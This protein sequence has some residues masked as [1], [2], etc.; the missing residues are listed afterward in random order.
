VMAA[1]R[2]GIRVI[3]APKDNLKDVDEIPPGIRGELEIHGVETVAQVL[4]LVLLPAPR[5]KGVRQA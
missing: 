4:K 3:L 1:H 5:R 2:A